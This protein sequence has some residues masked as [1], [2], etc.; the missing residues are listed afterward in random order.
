MLLVFPS[1]QHYTCSLNR[2]SSLNVNILFAHVLVFQEWK[3][4]FE[5]LENLV[6]EVLGTELDEN[7]SLTQDN[8]RVD[9]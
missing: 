9:A 2:Q 1:V 5:A 7:N 4:Q 8:S 3:K 6:K